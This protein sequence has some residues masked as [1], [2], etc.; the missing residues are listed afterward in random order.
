MEVEDV[1]GEWLRRN[2]YLPP[3]LL[4]FAHHSNGK[5]SIIQVGKLALQVYILCSGL[6][7]PHEDRTFSFKV[8]IAPHG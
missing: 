6:L 2:V 3:V 4:F 7:E 8:A 5:E 1:V